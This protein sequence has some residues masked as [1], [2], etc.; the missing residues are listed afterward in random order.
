MFGVSRW[1]WF[2]KGWILTDGE[3]NFDVDKEEIETLVGG[4]VVLQQKAKNSCFIIPCFS[5]HFIIWPNTRIQGKQSS[6]IRCWQASWCGPVE[7]SVQGTVARY[8]CLLI[9]IP[10]NSNSVVLRI[11]VRNSVVSPLTVTEWY[12]TNHICTYEH[13]L[14][15]IGLTTDPLWF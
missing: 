12:Y 4:G 1:V 2:C 9:F 13:L 6:S 10:T 15:T 14:Y 3:T 5:R 7:Y 11:V 8:I